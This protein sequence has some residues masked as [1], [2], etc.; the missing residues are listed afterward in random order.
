M[1]SKTLIIGVSG[2][3]ASGKTGLAKKIAS[4]LKN[5]NPNLKIALL[6]Q[7]HSYKKL[8]PQQIELAFQSK[9]NFDRPDAQD[10]NLFFK[11][12]KNISQKQKTTIPIYNFVIHAHD[13]KLDPQIID[14]VDVCITEGIFLFY[15]SHIR[16]LLDFKI[17]VD[18]DDDERLARRIERDICDRGRKVKLVLKEWRDFAKPGHDQFVCQTK[19]Y[20]DVIIPRGSFNL[21]AIDMVVSNIEKKINSL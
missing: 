16:N 6:S 12:L 9:Y 11:W 20:A 7:D 19:R 3:T 15:H 5:H 2:G 14:N 17:Y 8:T 18:V 4:Q 13:P 1:S 10:D 21:Q